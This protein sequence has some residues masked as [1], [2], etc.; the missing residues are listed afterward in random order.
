MSTRN[1]SVSQFEREGLVMR[2]QKKHPLRLAFRAR[3]GVEAATQRRD[4]PFVVLLLPPPPPSL[5]TGDRGGGSLSTHHLLRPPPSLE[6]RDGGGI[7][8]VDTP[9]PPLPHSKRETEGVV[10]CQHTTISTP[11][12]RSKRETEGVLFLS[13]HHHHLH[14]LPRSKR[15]ETST[16]AR[17]RG[18]HF[19]L[20]TT[21]LRYPPA[22]TTQ[23]RNE[24]Q[25]LILGMVALCPHHHLYH[26]RKQE[27]MLVFE[28]CLAPLP[29]PPLPSPPSTLENKSVCLFSRAAYH[30]YRLH[31]YY[32]HPQ[33]RARML[34][35][36][37]CLPPPPSKMSI[38][39]RFRGCLII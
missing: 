25:V 27:R 6:T 5:E 15:P 21:T 13:T 3:E 28:G 29:P 37:G 7:F 18:C 32:L 34:V 10:L 20:V 23:P 33:K 8:S 19:F 26:P 16:S 9:S 38:R 24:K 12:P 39:S 11:L 35:F 22:T 4:L 31:P 36:E 14:P 1:P 30:P 17:F 2:R